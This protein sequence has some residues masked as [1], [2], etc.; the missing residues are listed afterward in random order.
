MEEERPPNNHLVAFSELSSIIM[1]S[2]QTCDREHHH[3]EDLGSIELPTINLLVGQLT[4]CTTMRR[5][6]SPTLRARIIAPE[7]APMA[8]KDSA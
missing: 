3:E 4:S 1:L 6:V 2:S 7:K 8:F 5:T